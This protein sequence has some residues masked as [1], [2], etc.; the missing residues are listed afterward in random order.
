MSDDLSIPNP[1]YRV[2]YRSRPGLDPA[3]KRRLIYASGV[4]ALV[5][6]AGG[7]SLMF[8]RHP[9]PVPVVQA[10]SRPLRVKPDNP[11]GMQITG[12]GDDTTV[13]G[14]TGQL[15][16]GRTAQLAPPPEVPDPKALRAPPA[17]PVPAP[18]VT[19]PAPSVAVPQS[20]PRPPV[21]AQSA[22]A[23]PKPAVVETAPPVAKPAPT[24]ATKV[25]PSGKAP[26]IQLAALSSE[27]AARQEWQRLQKHLPDIL[28]GHSP[29]FVKVEHDGRTIWRLRITGFGDLAQARTFCERMR[30]KGANCSVADF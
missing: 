14:R 28:G 22:P 27:D 6:V 5:A 21:A 8:N 26:A 10:D 4:V 3:T 24:A 29:T 15:A 20:A 1:V 23:A 25:V 12:V 11:G 30:G 18:L 16:D 19:V 2:P 9:G 7:V 13:D 17:A